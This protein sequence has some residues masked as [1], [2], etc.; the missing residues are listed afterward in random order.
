MADP[1]P[2]EL[3]LGHLNLDLGVALGGAVEQA[4]LRGV[5][6]E[7]GEQG[8]LV[9]DRVHIRSSGE[10]AAWR[11]VRLHEPGLGEVGDGGAHDGDLG[12]GVQAGLR[13]RGRDGED[14]VHA[15]VREG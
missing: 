10:V 3:L 13:G 6:H 4:H 15:V 2:I 12:R 8:D 1:E 7:L 11:V 5:R 14:E 9:G